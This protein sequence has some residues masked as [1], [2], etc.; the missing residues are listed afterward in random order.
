MRYIG[1]KNRIARQIGVDLG[2]KTP[3]TKSYARLLKKINIPP[4]QHGNKKRKKISERGIQLKEKQKLKHIFCINEKQLKK[5]FKKSSLKKG[6]TALYLSQFLEL[7]LDNILYRLG[8]APT[9]NSARQL[10]TH[11]HI[12]IN[13]KKMNIPSYQV[14]LNDEISF[15]NEKTT[16]I[17]YIEKSLN[18][19]DLII[20][21]WLERN[22]NNVGKLISLPNSDEILKQ[23][24]LRLIIEYYSK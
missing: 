13:G 18:N 7:R 15:S 6:N 17:P 24:N 8:F 1:P 20:P 14:R 2:L 11:G 10:I 4:G 12:L 19:K 21:P 9:R 5:Y 3:G 16:K 22:N 23:V